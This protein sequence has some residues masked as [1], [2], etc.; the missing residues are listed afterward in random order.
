MYK[1]VKTAS[2]QMC[3]S[4]MLSV[5]KSKY[6]YSNPNPLLVFSIHCKTAKLKIR[7]GLGVAS[8][9]RKRLTVSCT[10]KGEKKFWLGREIALG[11]ICNRLRWLKIEMEL[12]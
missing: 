4:K 6:I 2:P 8:T 5:F 7:E 9:Q 10:K 1:A 3:S 12:Y 11:R